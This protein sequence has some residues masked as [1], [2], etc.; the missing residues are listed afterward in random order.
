MSKEALANYL[1]VEEEELTQSYYTGYDLEGYEDKDGDSYLIFVDSDLV[2]L[3]KNDLLDGECEIL[4][5]EIKNNNYKFTY[6][7]AI[8]IDMEV[9]YDAIVENL[10]NIF[11]S[12]ER[13]TFNYQGDTYI[14][15]NLI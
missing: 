3:C 11:D 12:C 2:R 5:D 7:E 15:F 13:Q 1:G 4:E 8:T 10:E 14:I 9:L 6:P